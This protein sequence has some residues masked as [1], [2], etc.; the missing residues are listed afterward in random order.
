MNP[1]LD[2]PLC[3]TL[4]RSLLDRWR[5]DGRTAIDFFFLTSAAGGRG[6]AS[7]FSLSSWIISFRRHGFPFSFFLCHFLSQR[8][9]PASCATTTYA[10]NNRA[11][12][13][14]GLG[15]NL[16]SCLKAIFNHNGFFFLAIP[17]VCFPDRFPP[18]QRQ[19]KTTG[20][21]SPHTSQRGRQNRLKTAAAFWGF[22]LRVFFLFDDDALALLRGRRGGGRFG[23]QHNTSYT[24]WLSRILLLRWYL[25]GHESKGGWW[26]ACLLSGFV[27]FST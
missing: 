8:P 11:L 7:I 24:A 20:R 4:S 13:S 21:T 2:S 17:P 15:S 1:C 26:M 3:C 9:S 18:V 5:D 22:H 16:A 14:V 25:I 19:D 23:K 6:P 27:F 10:S 12:F